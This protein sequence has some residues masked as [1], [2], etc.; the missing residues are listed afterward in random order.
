MHTDTQYRGFRSNS[1]H[2][3]DYDY[4]Q[5]GAYFIT[6]ATYKKTEI[7][8]Y[9]EED[10]VILNNKGKIALD[11]WNGIPAHFSSVEIDEF[12]VMPEHIHGIIWINNPVNRRDTACRVST[13][14]FGKPVRGSIPTIIRSYKSAVTKSI[15]MIDSQLQIWQPN[16][17][18]HI[19]RSE[20]DLENIRAYIKFNAFNRFDF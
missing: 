7:F 3:K 4:S 16:F 19:I 18:E 17:Y 5:P 13:E 12:I 2:I 20:D 1:H 9:I 8:G 14:R 15:H 11:C 10:R 6:I